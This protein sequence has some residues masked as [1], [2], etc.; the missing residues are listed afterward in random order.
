MST[1]INAYKIPLKKYP[2]L[3]CK[4]NDSILKVLDKI[5]K[6]TK[7]LVFVLDNKN[8]FIGTISDGDLRRSILINPNKVLSISKII[9]RKPH[10]CSD[11]S[12]LQTIL[13]I[14]FK[15]KFDLIP[16]I[17]AKKLI[18]F[19]EIKQ[20]INDINKNKVLIIAGGYG[21]R[22]LPYTKKIPK[23]LLLY[24]NKPI[25]E[26]LI[27]N[28]KKQGFYEILISLHYKSN[29]IKKH[30]G[31]GEKYGVK[32]EYINEEKPLGTAG[33]LYFLNTHLE[34]L[35]VINSDVLTE[36]DYKKLINFHKKHKSDLTISTKVHNIKNPYGVINSKKTKF[37]S[38]V[39][40]PD[41]TTNIN[42]GIY[43]ISKNILQTMKRKKRIDM[44]DLIK[45][46]Y[47]KGANIRCYNFSDD[48]IEFGTID[49][50][51]NL[52]NQ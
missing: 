22:L 27:L 10:I 39:E 26:H 50:F 7:R 46:N 9:N 33:C 4:V 5:N 3:T 23:P 51:Q 52:I 35:V 48:W 29:L 15:N 25:I 43:I 38:L 18:G 30:L 1:S 47:Q 17:K 20:K 24:K 21:K 44:T 16:I 34:D 19:Y 13:N 45:L 11:K 42:A 12:S 2:N 6:N 49:K 8:N 40:K 32:I 28:L 14:Y 37:L 31:N 36:L 41:H